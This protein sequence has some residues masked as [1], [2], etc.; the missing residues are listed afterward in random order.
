MDT[1]SWVVPQLIAYG[2]VKRPSLGV[3]LASDHIVRRSRIEG[4]VVIGVDTGSSAERA[5][6]RPAY[7]D[8]RGRVMVGDVIVALDGEKVQSGGEL[9]LLL[10]RHREGDVVTVTIEREGDKKDVRLKL[11]ASR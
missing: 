4:A 3:E 5:G 11:G 6:I 8:R 1:V 9:G 10:E 7:R 2:K